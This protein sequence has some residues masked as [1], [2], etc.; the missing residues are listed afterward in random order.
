MKF[1][2]YFTFRQS[3]LHGTDQER[4]KF[5]QQLE[6]VGSEKQVVEKERQTL[7][8]E[9]DDQQKQIEKLK[10][11][12]AEMKRKAEDDEDERVRNTFV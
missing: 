2:T 5:K 9:K 8:K 12:M 6:T 11:N 7:L 3:K 10:T 4:M 1:F